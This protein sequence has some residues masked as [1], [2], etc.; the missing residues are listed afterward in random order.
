MLES[1]PSVKLV[2]VYNDFGALYFIFFFSFFSFLPLS[3]HAGDICDDLRDKDELPYNCL[4]AGSWSDFFP[5]SGTSLLTH[6]FS[7]IFYAV[8]TYDEAEPRN[9]VANLEEAL[10]LFGTIARYVYCVALH[11]FFDRS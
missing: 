11:V 1:S 8:D 2:H 4:W 9:P 3:S 10:E 5:P 7:R 6:F